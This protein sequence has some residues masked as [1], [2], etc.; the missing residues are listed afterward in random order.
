MLIALCLD[1]LIRSRTRGRRSL[2]DV[3]RALWQRH[4]RAGIGVPEGE[5]ERIA[6]ALA[7]GSLRAF[8]NRALRTTGELPLAEMLGTLGIKS[9]MRLARDNSDRGGVVAAGAKHAVRTRSRSR[10]SLGVRVASDGEAVKINHVLDGGAAQAAGL[11]AND[12]IIAL[13]GIRVSAK[14]FDERVLRARAGDRLTV[15]AFRRDELFSVTVEARTAGAD[16]CDL[17]RPRGAR[18]RGLARWLGRA[19]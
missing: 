15:H 13:D 4:G 12:L 19:P 7:G 6:A 5:I 10:I 9:T 2:D 11:A 8:F 3:M 16:T 17:E 1:L 14:Q 18:G